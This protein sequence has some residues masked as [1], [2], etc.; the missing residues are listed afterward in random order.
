V[1]WDVQVQKDESAHEAF[2]AQVTQAASVISE[3]AG[4]EMETAE[5]LVRGGLNS[6]EMLAGGVDEVDIADILEISV[7]EGREIL[8][9][10]QDAVGGDSEEATE[11]TVVAEEPGSVESTDSA[12]E[13]SEDGDA[14]A[15]TEEAPAN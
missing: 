2:E 3:T 12:E 11:E 1:G 5:T 9:K 15:E 13:P 6:L 10:A 8:K 4:I 7:E 14:P